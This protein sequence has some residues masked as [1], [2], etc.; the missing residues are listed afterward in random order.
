MD[1]LE[2]LEQI[3]KQYKD[4]INPTDYEQMITHISNAFNEIETSPSC[5]SCERVDNPGRD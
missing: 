1:A 3:L 5:D 4:K 2:E